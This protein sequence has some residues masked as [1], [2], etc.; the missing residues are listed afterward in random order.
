MVRYGGI[1]N[2]T[3]LVIYAVYLAICIFVWI[4][5]R[6]GH[7][8]VWM[9]IAIFCLC[10]LVQVSLDL[11]A[12]EMFPPASAANTS[13]ESGVA[14]LTELGLTPLL[15]AT[16]SLLSATSNPKGRRMATI[17]LFLGIPLIVSLILIVAGGIDPDSR[18]GPTFAATGPTKAGMAIYVVCFGTLVWSTTVIST[19]IYMADST[20]VKILMT[21]V[22][23]LP[24]FTIV[25]VYF[26]CFAF[27]DL[28]GSQKFNVISGSVTLQLCMQVVEEYVIVAFYL[29]LGLGMP[30]KFASMTDSVGAIN[31]AGEPTSILHRFV[32]GEHLE[33]GTY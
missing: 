16:I 29:G 5:T 18:D 21:V 20:E 14:I 2:I 13:L 4:R 1:V 3:S 19:R 11:A 12:T 6:L 28:W 8:A 23:S 10:R 31:N 15:M 7:N 30:N 27:Q 22:L 24:F 9:W 17:L 32:T 26:L 25:V 33:R